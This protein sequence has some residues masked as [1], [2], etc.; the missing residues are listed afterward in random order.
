MPYMIQRHAHNLLWVTMHGHLVIDQAEAYFREMWQLLDGCPRPTD[1]LVDGRRISGA[2]GGARQRT[3][4]I[5]HH[6]HLGHI[7]F[8]VSEQHM[9]IFAP[10]VKLVSGIGLFGDEHA[11]LDYLRAARGLPPVIDLQLPVPRPDPAQHPPAAVSAPVVAPSVPAAHAPPRT[12][13]TATHAA[14]APRYR[15]PATRMLHRLADMVDG[16]AD[17]LRSRDYE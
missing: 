1:L 17:T 3:E 6:P 14:V 8:V 2:G 15:A 4:Q 11:A 7:A 9:L 10:L 16:W 12:V 13:P 5:A